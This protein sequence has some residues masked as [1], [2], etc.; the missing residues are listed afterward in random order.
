M[1]CFSASMDSGHGEAAER[2]ADDRGEQRAERADLGRRRDAGVEHDQHQQDQQQARPDPDQAG[3]ALGRRRAE[4]GRRVVGADPDPAV[5]HGGQQDADDDARDHAGDQ[6][7]A[8]RGLR[9]DAVDHHRDAGRNENVERGADADRAG[10]QL[11]GIAV[12]AH[13]RH[14]DLGHHRRRRGARPRHRAENSAGEHGRDR[15]PAADVRQPGGGGGVEILAPIR[16]MPR[17]RPSG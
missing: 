6:Q 3:A 12:P 5:D 11:L 4:R 17:S 8:D 16:S 2:R 13:L 1:V 9:R 7:L 14:R 15:K 10:R